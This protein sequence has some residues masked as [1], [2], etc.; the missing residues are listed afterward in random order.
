MRP[1]CPTGWSTASSR[2]RRSRTT[3]AGAGSPDG[4]AVFRDIS[5]DRWERSAQNPV[6]FLNDLWPATQAAAERDP[7]A[8][9]PHRRARRGGRGRPSPARPPPAGRPRARSP[10]SA[11]SSGSTS[12]CRSTRAVSAS[13]RATSSRR[14]ATR[15]CPMVGIGLFYGRGY[16]RQRLDLAGRQQEYWLVNEPHNLPMARVTTPDGSPLRLS[17]ER[18]RRASSRSMSG[19]STSAGCRCCSSTADVP[20]NDPVQRWTTG[21]PVRGEPRRPAGAVRAAR[22]RRRPRPARARDRAGRAAPERGPRLAGGA[23]ARGRRR[24]RPAPRSGMRSSRPAQRVVF[25][26]HT[27]VAAGNETYSAEE[28]MAAYGDLR[29][30]AL[31]LDGHRF[32]ALC[33]V[34]PGDA[35]ERPG[36]TPLAL[37][38]SRRRNAV[39]ELHGTVARQMWR[40]AVRR[41]RRDVPI[42]HVTNGAHIPTFLGE[43]L[44]GCSTG[45]SAR[46]G[47]GT[48]RTRRGG[49][50]YDGSRT[51]SSGRLAA[52]PAPGWSSTS[53]AG[54]SRTGCCGA[55]RSTTSARSPASLDPEALTLGFAR[56]L[57]TYKRLHLLALRPRPPAGDRRRRAPG[58]APDRREGAPER[59]GRQGRRS[60][61]SSG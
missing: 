11:P 5:P 4:P 26:T 41:T 32:L 27:P 31:G 49:S 56:R 9:G 1:R 54:S 35:D 34:D 43:P 48:P 61:A 60:S 10:S 21:A 3:T 39:S 17:V 19:A 38:L 59:R 51:R 14:R 33:R 37:R 30:R 58:A 52:R 2:W 22:H 18:P 47:S 7:V 28:F 36:M 24:S 12:R 6:R 16:F 23:R 15:P 29:R 57:A 13:W 20:E 25:T 45:T 8:P 53:A 55:S 50:P 42:T 40:P 46:A 44:R